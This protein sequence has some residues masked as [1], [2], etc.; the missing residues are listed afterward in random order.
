MPNALPEPENKPAAVREM[1]D[2]IAPRYD[3]LNRLLTFG[4]DRRWRRKL[5]E[6]LA[7]RPQDVVLDLACGTGDLAILARFRTRRVIGLDFSARMLELA[8]RRT[9]GR[10]S[11]VRGD[12][13]R[14]PLADSSLT[15]A[16]SGFALRNF[17]S[18][19]PVFAELGRVLRPGGRLGLLE[20]GRP[21]NLLVRFGHG[22]YFR[23][24]VP[25]V[26][27]LFDRQAYRYL[28]E[29][30]AYLPPEDELAAMLTAAGFVRIRRRTHLLGAI[31]EI[32]AVRR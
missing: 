2:R 7:I 23:G 17:A 11:L 19:P 29:S 8:S 28:P 15:V 12:G 20:V 16:A 4:L 22:L 32:T 24:V 3:W 14:L 27:R 13:L 9:A 18:L 31:Q 1:F 30:V 5:I 21:S 25:L 10:V 26:G 6:R